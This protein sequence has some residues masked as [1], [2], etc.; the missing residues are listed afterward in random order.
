M[1]IHG[2]QHYGLDSKDPNRKALWEPVSITIDQNEQICGFWN[3]FLPRLEETSV[4]HCSTKYKGP[5]YQIPQTRFRPVKIRTRPTTTTHPQ[6]HKIN[7]D[8]IANTLTSKTGTK[9]AVRNEKLRINTYGGVIPFL[10]QKP[11]IITV[12]CAKITRLDNEVFF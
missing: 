1:N 5:D 6:H 12:Q 4:T 3:K 11:D 9:T 7:I 8:D 2:S 10:D